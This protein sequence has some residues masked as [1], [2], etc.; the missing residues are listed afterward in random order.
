LDIQTWTQPR[1]ARPFLWTAMA[2]VLLSS[3]LWLGARTAFGGDSGGDGG[4]GGALSGGRHFH[5]ACLQNSG[6]VRLTTVHLS[7]TPPT[8]A[9][10][11]AQILVIYGHQPTALHPVPAPD[12]PDRND[13]DDKHAHWACLDGTGHMKVTN[14]HISNP[15]Q[16]VGCVSGETAVGLFYAHRDGLPHPYP[17]APSVPIDPKDYYGC[18]AGQGHLSVTRILVVGAGT[19]LGFPPCSQGQIVI[20][21]PYALSPTAAV[22]PESADLVDAAVD[23]G[24][25]L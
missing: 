8:C 15:A 5:Y 3:L 20:D 2:G 6:F 14:N 16:P 1:W 17:G 18:M 21:F 11:E 24:E 25:Q 10:N 13:I 4:D 7:G 12:S 22:E 9:P 23:P 19:S